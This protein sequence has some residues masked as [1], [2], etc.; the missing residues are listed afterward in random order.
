M[1]LEIVR[2]LDNVDLFGSLDVVDTE[3]PR[4]VFI[5]GKM[6]PAG[7]RDI[8]LAGI[9]SLQEKYL[10]SVEIAMAND[11]NHKKG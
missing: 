5:D 3:I 10:R 4:H 9:D 1:K 7:L 8:I 2:N 11:P 6:C